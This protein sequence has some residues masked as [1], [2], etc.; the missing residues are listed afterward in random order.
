MKDIALCIG[1]C[2]LPVS[3]NFGAQ[4]RNLVLLLSFTSSFAAQ[5]GPAVTGGGADTCGEQAYQYSCVIST[6][7]VDGT[8]WPK[9]V[10][11]IKAKGEAYFD[12]QPSTGEYLEI[13]VCGGFQSDGYDRNAWVTIK[14]KTNP[15]VS[16]G[17]Q[18]DFSSSQERFNLMAKLGEGS[19]AEKHSY[20]YVDCKKIK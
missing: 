18:I 7:V 1:D 20:Y 9:T 2:Y 16:G 6:D 3:F 14:S 12:V 15:G 8:K 11:I 5:A 10:Q 4:M 19:E 13:G 17:G